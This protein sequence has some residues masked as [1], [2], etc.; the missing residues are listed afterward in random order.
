[1]KYIEYNNI[2]KFHLEITSKCNLM[3]PSCARTI[4]FYDE[5]YENNSKEYKNIDITIDDI[6]RIF[7]DEKMLKNMDLVFFCGNYS[8]PTANKDFLE[9]ITFF[10]KYDNID[11]MV[12]TNGSLRNE[13]WWKELAKILNKKRDKVI[14]SIDGLYQTNSIYRINSNFEKII[15]NAKSF[16]DSGGNAFWDF[17]VFEHN[18]NQMDEAIELSRKIGFKEIRFK[19]S[20]RVNWKIN[21][22]NKILK[23][24]NPIIPVNIKNNKEI[25]Q[26][27]IKKI[28]GSYENYKK[29]CKVKCKTKENNSLYI[30]FLQRLWPCCW[31]A[32]NFMNHDN[33][34][35]LDLV[36]MYEY[37]NN[38]YEFNSLKHKSIEEILKHD[39]FQ[40]YLYQSWNDENLRHSVCGKVCGEI[41]EFSSNNDANKIIVKTNN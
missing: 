15:S 2:K 31:F 4:S 24:L 18:K 41:M 22:T 32:A 14:F 5:K 19:Q 16:I 3:C 23:N 36:R 28:Y 20:H 17:L 12:F 11:L 38:D 40:N 6:K 25:I 35:T 37:Y 29:K 39:F 8:E 7:H 30:D 1:M 26:E 13:N 33:P 34:E 21:T 27:E 9:I 10:S